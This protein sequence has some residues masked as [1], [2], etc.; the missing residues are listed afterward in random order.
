MTS[1]IL[2]WIRRDLRLSDNSALSFA[3]QTGRPVVP[4]FI[5]DEAGE[6]LGAAP[7]WRLEQGLKALAASY[8]EHG[9]KLILR[10]GNVL[11]VLNALI[12]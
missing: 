3:S 1:P 11:E 9:V 10:R 7:K 2:Y 4:V 5:L 6:A 12:D 8:G